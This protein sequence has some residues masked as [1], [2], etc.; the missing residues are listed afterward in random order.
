MRLRQIFLI[1]HFFVSLRPL[2]SLRF[3]SHGSFLQTAEAQR[4]QTLIDPATPVYVLRISI[5]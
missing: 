2:R 4:R 1:S 3:V 5:E